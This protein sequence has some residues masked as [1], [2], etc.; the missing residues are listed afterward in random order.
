[1]SKTLLK[2]EKIILQNF[3]ASKHTH[4]H[5][6]IHVCGNHAEKNKPVLNNKY[7]VKFLRSRK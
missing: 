4:T 1:M 2:Y 3:K 5:T 7:V 6:H